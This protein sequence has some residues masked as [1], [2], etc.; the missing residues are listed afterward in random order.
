MLHLMLDGHPHIH[1]PGEVDF[2]F[3][4]IGDDGSFPDP[5]D[6]YEWLSLDRI[7]LSYKLNI[8]RTLST[9]DLIR[10]FVTQLKQKD[11]VLALNIHR[12]FHRVP[13]V[14]P[15]AYY[16]HLIRDPR[17][18][19]RSSIGMGWVG[20]V[21]YGVEHWLKTEESWQLL[22]PKIDLERTYTL[23]YEELITNTEQTLHGLC[24]FMGL[25]YSN[26]LLDYSEK[27]TYS[28]PDVSLTEQWKTKLSIHEI[29]SVESKAFILMS[30]YEFELSNENILTLSLFQK[31]IF[32]VHNLI[33]KNIF[34]LK[35][36]SVMLYLAEKI[37]R[38][39]HVKFIYA[40]TRRRCNDIDN[41]FLK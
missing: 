14:F 5:K 30:K 20:N 34:S 3:D 38:R 26:E 13:Y 16:I 18:V 37:S 27:S 11:E 2:L 22:L 29:R 19:A 40:L 24:D 15:E 21:Y 35:R 12:D 10:Y 36:Y 31:S 7:F 9:R 8:D 39:L 6:F 33:Y 17:D 32:T 1:N 4:C 41:F 28:K 25:Q 23:Y